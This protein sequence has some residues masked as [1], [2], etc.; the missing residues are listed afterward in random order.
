M[1]KPTLD[2]IRQKIRLNFPT[3]AQ[4]R[5]EAPELEF[6]LESATTKVSTCHRYR[7]SKV[8]E[9]EGPGFSYYAWTT[10]SPTLAPKLVAGPFITGREAM[11]AARAHARGEPVQANL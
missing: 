3:E 5:R 10:A 7:I 11:E 8:A 9:E 2:E 1:H 6:A 4:S